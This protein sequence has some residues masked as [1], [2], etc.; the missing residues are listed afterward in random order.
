MEALWN[1]REPKK[2]FTLWAI[3]IAIPILVNVLIWNSWVLPATARLRAGEEI[4]KMTVLKPKL[5]A[6]LTQTHQLFGGWEKSIFTKDDPSRAMQ[7]IQ[8]LGTLSHVDIKEIRSKGQKF[9][10]KKAGQAKT[11]LSGYSE[12]SMDLEVRGSFGRLLRWMNEV[13]KQGGLEIDSWKLVPGGKPGEPHKLTV[14]INVF[15]K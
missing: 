1:F 8:R 11:D 7:V 5:E 9:S 3:F 4:Q 15:L 10:E 14:G 12:M 6:L 2:C 13:E